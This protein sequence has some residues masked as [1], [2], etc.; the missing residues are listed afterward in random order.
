MRILKTTQT[1][2]PYLSKGGPPA[3]VSGIAKALVRRGHEV[4]VLTADLGGTDGANNLSEWKRERNKWGWETREDG[5]E[6]I[7]LST[8]T[9]YRATTV[10]PLVASFCLARLRDYDVVHVYGLYDLIGA[11]VAWF[12][13]R[14]GIPYVLEPLGMS[15]SKLRSAQKKRLYGR[16]LG[17]ALFDGADTIIATSEAEHGELVDGGID[18]GKIILRRNG[19][20]LN[21]FQN[22][23]TPGAFR[24]KHKL[25][26]KEPLILFLGRLSF[27]K[28]LDLFVEAFS[29]VAKPAKLVIAGPDDND[30]CVQKI[31]SLINELGLADRVILTGP[32]YGADKLQAMVDADFF[33][34]P[35]RYESFGNALA[36]S[37]ACGT[38]GLVTDKCGIATL[39]N[40]QAALVVTCDVQ[41]LR[42][43][44]D[45]LVEDE[46]LLARLREGC[47]EVAGKL[48]WDEPVVMME[49]LYASL[50][51]RASVP[52]VAGVRHSC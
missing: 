44:M 50:L 36:E 21:E 39:V 28:G 48:S 13:R 8:L 9:N 18:K 12:C 34:L 5:V 46:P 49:N 4:T 7:Y 17:T 47:A 1:Y 37:I 24:S 30:G 31:R 25:D 2:Y 33:V 38:P 29:Q 52:A 11:A 42:Q 43:G 20:N 40:N 51:T 26:K 16:L 10:N 23:P 22:L 14:R 15:G 32:L 45:R 3:K 6:A 35:S 41:G 27:I 19:L